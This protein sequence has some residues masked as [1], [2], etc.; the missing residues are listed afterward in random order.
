[1]RHLY[2]LGDLELCCEK[3]KSELNLKEVK[4]EKIN[5]DGFIYYISGVKPIRNL[6]ITFENNNLEAYGEIHYQNGVNYY[7]SEREESL[8]EIWEKNGVEP[9]HH[10]VDS[11]KKVLLSNNIKLGVSEEGIE[12]LLNV[13]GKVLIAKGVAPIDDEEDKVKSNFESKIKNYNEE[14]VGN[15]D[16]RNLYSITNVEPGTVIGE[17]IIG[18]EGKDGID[19]FG[20][21]IHR[22]KKKKVNI[23]CGQGCKLSDNRAISTVAGRPSLSG[24]TFS[25]NSVYK[26]PA[27]V[28][29]KTGNIDFIGD[30]DIDGCIQEGMKVKSGSVVRV[31]GSVEK[32]EVEAQGGIYINGNII[33]STLKAGA[34]D[35]LK[36]NCLIIL[37]EY[38]LNLENLLKSLDQFKE[39]N[40]KASMKSDGELIKLLIETKFG[41]LSKMAMSII[42]NTI[43][44]IIEEKMI[45]ETVKG[46]IMG[47]APLNIKFANELYNLIELIDGEIKRLKNEIN[48]K[49]D[50]NINYCQDTK[51]EASGD[52][53]ILGKGQYVSN[54]K[55]LQRINF[56]NKNSV[57]RGGTLEAKHSINAGVIGTK[58]GAA[59]T[60]KV[61]KNG[62]IT[63][64]RVYHNTNFCIGERVHTFEYECKDV[65][66]YL[67]KCG[68]LEIEKFNV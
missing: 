60:L 56:K 27:N 17:K 6:N 31:N 15:V 18:K 54:M 26:N 45:S 68:D 50:V 10:T 52:I 32:A 5:E 65:K 3:L 29:I 64:E 24:N 16:F 58:A 2:T 14:S 40:M 30:V 46:K 4:L 57:C 41:Y 34:K 47:L 11:I 9:E 7:I 25:V 22:N 66:A 23:S 1:M 37:E 38:K 33:D 35:V 21:I 49:V 55:S 12:A 8:F 48:I 13:N 62:L 28:D 43:T 42:T 59:T 51:I 67:N 61:D 39:Y 53:N 44:G 20:N 63:A 19:V 36:N